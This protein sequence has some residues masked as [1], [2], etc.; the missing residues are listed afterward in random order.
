MN[1]I[2]KISVWVA[3][4]DKEGFVGVSKESPKLNESLIKLTDIRV[5]KGELTYK[6][7]SPKG[8]KKNE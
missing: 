3:I 5:L 8:V 4:S 6:I 2:V 1:K 7:T